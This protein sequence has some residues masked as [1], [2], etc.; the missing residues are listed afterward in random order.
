VASAQSAP[1]TLTMQEAVDLALKNNLDVESAQLN[2]QT[3]QSEL[4]RAWGS[5]APDIT[6]L[7]SYTRNFE[8]PSA[9]MGG[10]KVIVAQP[11]SMRHSANLEQILFAGGA[12]SSGIRAARTGVA[13]ELAQFD[14]SK[15]DAVLAVRRLFYAVLLASDTARIQQDNLASSEDHLRT[16]KERY[17]QGLDSDLTLLRQQVETANAKPAL[18]QARNALEVSSILLK[19]VLGLDVDS[20]TSFSGSLEA[21]KGRLPDYERLVQSA[22]ESNADN[23]AARSRAL[24][25]ESRFHALKGKNLPWLSLT[26]NYQWYSESP[27]RWP[28]NQ[29]RATSSMGGLLLRWP[30]FTGGD[31]SESIRQARIQSELARTASEKIGRSVRVRLKQAWLSAQEAAERARSQEEAVG[32]ARR[33]L[34]ATEL[35]YRAG[36]SSQLELTDATL[37]LQRARLFY[38]QALH[39]YRAQLAALERAAGSPVVEETTP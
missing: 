14:A 23:R 35:R 26:A 4:R 39:D 15:E 25:A 20:P 27:D 9:F 33:A 1:K 5:L 37:A 13:A 22:L 11:Y 36:Q 12:V 24:Q 34:E 17:R 19:D 8:R 32:Q 10:G 38:A 29:E 21:P 16:I 7:G 31:I 18:L 6:L 3:A 28:D 30:L 2:L